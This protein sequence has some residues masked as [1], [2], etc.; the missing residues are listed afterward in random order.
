MAASMTVEQEITHYLRL[1]EDPG[2]TQPERDLAAH[3][4]ERLLA[5]HAID[6]LDLDVE[7]DRTKAAEPIA[8]ASVRCAGG[9]G[10]VALDL[11]LGLADVARALGLYP[12]YSDRRDLPAMFA[13]TEDEQPHVLLSVSGFTS[14]VELVLPLLES[15][16]L[17]AVLALRSWWRSDP[18]HRHMH[19]YDALLSKCAFARSFGQGAAARLRSAREEA[20]A[21]SGKALAVRSREEHV[22]T[23][24]DGNLSLTRARRDRRSFTGYGR[25]EGY[26]AG[27]HARTGRARAVG[28]GAASSRSGKPEG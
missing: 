7:A 15:L 8:S 16:Q 19:R 20:T 9:K 11:A 21:S 14:D 23:W 18:R 5:K 13:R 26:R 28:A 10:T 25:S 17:Q 3:R 12:Y 27:M 24:V 6:R 1:S 4:A 2:A 22:R